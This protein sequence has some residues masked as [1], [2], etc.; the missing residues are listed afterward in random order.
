MKKNLVFVWSSTLIVITISVFFPTFFNDFQRS[1][2]DQWMLLEQPY[3]LDFSWMDLVYHFGSFYHGQYSP[4]NTVFYL[5]IYSL[6]GFNA[7]A[8]HAA[9]L[10]IHTINVLLVSFVT[11]VIIEKIK[12]HWNERRIMVYAGL[13]SLLFAIHPLQVE[14]VAWISASKIVLYAFFSLMGLLF[15]LRYLQTTKISW[16]LAVLLCYLLAFGTKEQAIIFPLN[17]ILLDWVLGRY[18]PA[19]FNWRH[20]TKDVFIEKMP[21]FLLAAAMWYF[22]VQNNLGNLDAAGAYPLHQRLVFGAHSLVQ[23]IFRF[24]APVKLYYWYFYPMTVGGELPLSYWA[25]PLLAGIVL[26]FAWSLWK[27]RNHLPVFGFAFFTVNLLLALHIVPMPRA[28]ITADRY[29]YLSI[30]GLALACIWLI[31][32]LYLKFRGARKGVLLAGCMLF[33]AFGIQSFTRTVDWRNSEALRRNIQEIV[34]KRKKEQQ[35]VANNPLEDVPK[36]EGVI[37]KKGGMEK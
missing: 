13:V 28:T 22:S 30:P 4:V 35:A 20:I 37:Q 27:K 24:L 33:V 8:F 7:A 14:S 32:Y 23:Y 21:F 25:Y 10:L 29:M 6:F 1:W 16:Y 31:G 19:P 2:D 18:R 12:P 17:L 34:E 9:C 26:V 15:Y 36:Q 11:R 3:I 5:I